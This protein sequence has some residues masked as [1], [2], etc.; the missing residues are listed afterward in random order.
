[1]I[2]DGLAAPRVRRRGLVAGGA[3]L[4]VLVACGLLARGGRVGSVERWFFHAVNDLPGWLY[5][6]MWT[7]EQMGNLGVALAVTLAVAVLLRRADL[8]AVAGV[9]VVAKLVL[10]RVVK[11]VVKRPRP[12]TTIGDIVRRGNVPAHGLSFVSGHAVITA[13]IATMLMGVLPR[14]WRPV[15]W[16][17]VALNGLARIYVGAHNPLD[18][19][20]GVAL[21]L[22]IGAPLYVL[23]ATRSNARANAPIP[24][25]GPTR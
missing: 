8:A 12:G 14:R 5:R 18:V 1:V 4:A 22:V 6:P 17:V 15:P 19:V 21:G 23:L 16:A 20:G 25:A 9:A 24:V 7:F 13:A 11:A 3:G 2:P 10:E